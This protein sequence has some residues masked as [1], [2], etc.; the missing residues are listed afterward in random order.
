MI[1]SSTGLRDVLC[2]EGEC[3]GQQLMW[4]ATHST[5]IADTVA[6]LLE[7][8]PPGL[9]YANESAVYINETTRYIY[10]HFRLQSGT[11]SLGGMSRT[12]STRIGHD[13]R[14]IIVRAQPINMY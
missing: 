9:A 8:F 3:K 5:M 13:L 1:A 2:H 14:W 6:S 11:S 12:S 7:R 10:S 4:N